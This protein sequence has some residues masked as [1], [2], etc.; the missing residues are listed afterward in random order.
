[1]R[2]LVAHQQHAVLV[3]DGQ[4]GAE[5]VFVVGPER[6]ASF[7]IKRQQPAPWRPRDQG[8]QFI[9]LL[10]LVGGSPPLGL[11]VQR[12]DRVTQAV[13][14][15][16]RS[17]N[18]VHP[19][20]TDRNGVVANRPLGPVRPLD[21]PRVRVQGKQHHRLDRLPA[22]IPVRRPTS[23]EVLF[24]GERTEQ[25]AAFPRNVA[26]RAR[27]SI[28][29]RRRFVFSDQLAGIR[30]QPEA[31]IARMQVEVFTAQAV[32]PARPGRPNAVFAMIRS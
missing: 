24:I 9:R 23:Y 7:R 32:I 4:L 2:R 27:L 16:D 1:M 22:G 15:R 20:L 5:N 28:G 21:L 31:A 8:E 29:P 12:R 6:L 10:G 19:A 26:P 14:F 25:R 13:H 18:Q 17:V 30:G 3:A 11:R